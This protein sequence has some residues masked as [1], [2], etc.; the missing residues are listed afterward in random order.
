[1]HVCNWWIR[2]TTL[3]S[4]NQEQLKLMSFGG[5]GRGHVFF[6][7]HGWTNGGRTE[8]KYTSRAAE[9]YR[10]LLA[11]EVAKSVAAAPSTPAVSSVPEPTVNSVMSVREEHVSSFVEQPVKP[12]HLPASPTRPG[13]GSITRKPPSL[14]AKRLVGSKIGGGLGVRKLTSKVS[15][16]VQKGCGDQM[17]VVEENWLWNLDLFHCGLTHIIHWCL[18]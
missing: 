1:M 4:W 16:G 15:S 14:G 2:S 18:L 3:D 11:K 10:Q 13:L 7:Q 5:N 17:T 6:K 9:L 8:S 12:T